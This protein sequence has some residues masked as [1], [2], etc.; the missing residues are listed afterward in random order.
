[1]NTL[2]EKCFTCEIMTD[3]VA[4]TCRCIHNTCNSVIYKHHKTSR[5]LSPA[6]AARLVW[7]PRTAWEMYSTFYVGG[8]TKS[9]GEGYGYRAIH[10]MFKAL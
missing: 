4:N 5:T 7:E 6:L 9:C 2:E 8:T 3:G 1:M 10:S